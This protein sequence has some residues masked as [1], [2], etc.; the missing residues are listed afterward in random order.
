MC[1][2]HTS[3][4]VGIASPASGGPRLGLH[5]IQPLS[6][7]T[8]LQEFLSLPCQV[9]I[10]KFFGVEDTNFFEELPTLCVLRAMFSQASGKVVGNTDITLASLSLEYVQRDGRRRSEIR[11]WRRYTY[12]IGC[13]NHVRG[14]GSGRFSGRWPSAFA[15]GFGGHH[16]SLGSN[17]TL[18]L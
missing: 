6:S 18:V 2:R 3:P 9:V 16:P 1:Q 10:G 11:L 12:F 17:A 8:R 14:Q 7:L 15:R 13:P 4:L 5:F